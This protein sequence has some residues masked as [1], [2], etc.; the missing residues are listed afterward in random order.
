MITLQNIF[1]QILKEGSYDSSGV[2]D[3]EFDRI[4]GYT[5]SS[6]DDMKAKAGLQQQQEKPADKL[7]DTLIYRN[8]K[9]LSNFDKYV[10]AIA[11]I[12]GELFVAQKDGNFNHFDMVQKLGINADG[13]TSEFLRLIRVMYKDLFFV[14]TKCGTDEK[15]CGKIMD[16]VQKKNPQYRFIT[17]NS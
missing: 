9:D 10:R 13:E 11:T 16:I 8:P 14:L 2:G 7:G 17:R 12:K 15:K 5:S 3:M 6:D 1:N 4:L